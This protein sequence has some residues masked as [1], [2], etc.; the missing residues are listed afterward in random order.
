MKTTQAFDQPAEPSNNDIMASSCQTGASGEQTQDLGAQDLQATEEYVRHCLRVL[1]HSNGDCRQLDAL[2]ACKP[3]EEAAI[4]CQLLQQTDEMLTFYQK[5]LTPAGAG[6]VAVAL[7]TLRG[8]AKGLHELQALENRQREITSEMDQHRRNIP[9][10]KATIKQAREFFVALLPQ[11]EAA[12]ATRAENDAKAS[13]EVGSEEAGTDGKR[14]T[15]VGAE[16]AD[17]DAKKQIEVD[18]EK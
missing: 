9:H 6:T 10:A 1:A 15:D 5:A 12:K 3:E 17:S 13:T 14:Q 16:E 2:E 4:I 18:S 11:I 8:L 7:N